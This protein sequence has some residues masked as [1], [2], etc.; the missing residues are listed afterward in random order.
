MTP[1]TC[2]KAVDNIRRM[3]WSRLVN[4]LF[5]IISFIHFACRNTYINSP[6]LLQPTYRSKSRPGLFFAG[7]ITGV[8][9]YVESAS[10]GLVAGINAARIAQ[11]KEPIIFPADTAHGALAHY[12]TTADPAH[13]QPMN[14]NFGLFPP[15]GVKSRDKKE[16]CRIISVNAQKSIDGCCLDSGFI[17]GGQ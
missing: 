8:E 6:L 15:P 7:Q 5:I 14:I 12:I 2:F 10:S 13:F 16:R 11:G 17:I 9:G 1:A 4:F 3:K